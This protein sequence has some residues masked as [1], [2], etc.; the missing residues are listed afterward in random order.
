MQLICTGLVLIFSVI[1][2]AERLPIKAYTVADGLPQNNINSITQEAAGFFW[3]CTNGGLARFDGYN[4]TNF[5]TSEGL[6][7]D[8]VKDFLAARDGNYWLA[9]T[10]G[11][12]KFT[13]DGKV[14]DR[15]ITA[16][17]A[18]TLA[19]TPVF[20]TYSLPVTGIKTITKLIEDR[21]GTIWVG[22]GEGLFRLERSGYEFDLV[23]VELDSGGGDSSRYVFSL[24]E[25]RSGSVWSGTENSLFR[26]TEDGPSAAYV[27]NESPPI[28]F[29]T[30]LED[31]KGNFWVGTLKRG[32]FQFSIDQNETPQP[33]R[34]VTPEGDSAVNW[35]E[36]IVESFDGKIWLGTSS[37]LYEFNPEASKFYRYTRQSGLGDDRYLSMFED[38]R[39]DLW[40]GTRAKGVFR[41]SRR[42]LISFGSE[43]DIAFIRSISGTN[44]GNAL[45][46]GFLNNKQV[47]QKGAKVEVTRDSKVFGHFL[48]RIGR[49]GENG[50]EWLRPALDPLIYFGSGEN[51]TN[52]QARNGEWWIVTGEGLFRYPKV[53]FKDLPATQAMTVLDK[54]TGLVPQDVFRIFEDSRGDVWISTGDETGT[55]FF[56]WERETEKLINVGNTEGLPTANRDLISSFAEDRAGNLWIGYLNRGFARISG[57][58]ARFFDLADGVP[59]GGANG[60]FVDREGRLWVASGREGVVRIDEPASDNPNIIKVGKIEGLSSNRTFAL[61]QDLQGLIYIATDRD[62]NRLDPATGEVKIL[63]IAS[64]QP[65]REFRSAFC[66]VKG[67]L[68]F[69][70]TSGLVKYVPLPEKAAD[71][72]EVLLTRVEIEGKPQKVSLVG[73]TEMALR[74]LEPDENQVRIDF[75]SLAALTDEDVRYQYKFDS[76]PDW[77]QSA[78]ERFVNFAGLAAGD[79][80][81]MFRAVT[82]DGLVSEKPALV[83]F[84]VLSP[85]Y[86][87]WWFLLGVLALAV[88]MVY[89][90]YRFRLRRLLEMERM[91]TRIAADLHD[92]IGAN[93]TRISLLSEVAKQKSNNGNE[94]ML[95]SIADIARESVA[96]MNDIV[97]AISPDHDR[98]LD[99][100]R[101]MRQHA[102]EIFAMRDIELDFDAPAD[103][104]D[105]KLSVGVRRDVLLIFKEAVNNAARHSGCSK[106]RIDFRCENSILRLRIEDNGKGFDSGNSERD[107]QGLRSMARR[108]KA[109]GGTLT[110]EASKSGGTGV[111]FEFPLPKMN[112]M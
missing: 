95:G 111:D 76:Q 46:T 20:I 86:L 62:I 32:L 85:V 60:M 27:S 100:T 109:L 77:S 29:H 39:G 106:V 21:R 13:P 6:P 105:L 43:D 11:L 71:P 23:R 48:W 4:F 58:A 35:I 44:D 12:V 42:G 45:I 53:D 51:Q 83:S 72:P 17:E 101:R 92:D 97:W 57:G 87:R 7:S 16:E 31:T 22:T 73:V 66:D 49:W 108:S 65:Q 84:K 2:N 18:L 79:Y 3:F 36:T 96:S 56:K 30:L 90:F 10:G 89:A 64:N 19:E 99:L 1:A 24:Y 82:G 28:Y 107:G 59:Q 9:T 55:G 54:K 5:T 8:K 33:V 110:I 15:V 78:S 80:N 34:H 26:I 70:T 41:L 68:W 37:G 88:F 81:I 25:D 52:F 47:E 91:R 112:Q 50:L 63:K 102:E 98:M 103:D 61:T 14:Y 69:G 104:A 93:L 38:K 40:L 75:T 94:N 67:V 74:T